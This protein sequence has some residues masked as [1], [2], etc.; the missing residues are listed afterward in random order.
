MVH[1][2]RQV[3]SALAEAHGIGLIHRDIKPDNIILCERGGIPD[4]A[5]VVDFG[6]VKRPRRRPDPRS[7]APT[8]SRA[9]RSTS[10]PRRS[11]RPRSVDAR[12]DLYALGAVAYFLL[13]GQHVFGGATLVEVCAHHL[14]TA[15]ASPSER[16]GRPLP[17]A[18]EALVLS[19]LE[20]DPQRRPA[21][22]SALERRLAEVASALPWSE[23]EAREWWERWRERP[24]LAHGERPAGSAT[25]SVS[26]LNRPS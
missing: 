9:R 26:L 24:D 14:H 1:V 20:K 23:A 17:P 25:L 2:L 6:L 10:R 4:V 11:A 7:R 16:L 19:C 21:S 3:A 13:C 15:P 18:L 5:K 12:S 8:W 22:A